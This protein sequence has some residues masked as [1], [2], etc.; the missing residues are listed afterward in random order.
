MGIIHKQNFKSSNSFV[1]QYQN[2]LWTHS[3]RCAIGTLWT[4][5]HLSL[6]NIIP[7]AFIAG[8][9]H[10]MGKLYILTAL[11]KILRDK[12]A[13]I[14]PTPELMEK[15]MDSLH[16]E[17]GYALLSKWNLP[18]QYRNIARDH[19]GETYDHSDLLL[20]IVRLVNEVCLKME[21]KDPNEDLSGIISSREADILGLSEITIAQL[22]IALED[23][24]AAT[25]LA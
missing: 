23:A 25:N 14:K 9:L 17:L 18:E 3:V 24:M 8:L 7:K 21:R 2:R 13:A 4:A 12:T 20:L 10:D 15:I 1:R 16:Q 22:E 6:D 19:H 5:R 11:E